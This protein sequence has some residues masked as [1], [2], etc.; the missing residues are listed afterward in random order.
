[1]TRPISG[2]TDFNSLQTGLRA[3][4]NTTG[5]GLT[6][7]NIDGW[8][9]TLLSS[10]TSISNIAVSYVTEP[11]VVE[12]FSATGANPTAF[13]VKPD[14]GSTFTLNAV[15]L[16]IA[17][18][19]T[20][21]TLTGYLAGS[22]VT[23]ATLTQAVQDSNATG[24]AV[25]FNVSSN[26]AFQGIDSFRIT[27]AS[28]AVSLYAVDN[29]NITYPGPVFTL[30]SGSAAFVEANNAVST[31]VP[32]DPGLTLA[33][34][35]STTLASATVAITVGFISGQ[36]FLSFINNGTEGNI[37]ASFNSSTGALTLTS[38]GGTATTAEWQ[39]ALR[40]V[41]YTDTAIVP[42]TSPRTVSFSANDGTNSS[43]AVSRGVTVTAT[44]QSP[45]VTPSSAT[46]VVST[47]PSTPVAIDSGITVTDLSAS[48]LASATVAITADFHPGEDVLAFN[49]GVGGTGNIVGSYN[50]ST[51]VLTL[52]SSGATATVAQFQTALRDVTFVDTAAA[53]TA[54]TRTI[55]FAVNDGVATSAVATDTVTIGTISTISTIS[56]GSVS[57]Y[58]F[59]DTT[60]GTQ[61]LT[62]NA[63]EASTITNP[64]SPNY[65]PNLVAQTTGFGAIS[66][67]ASDP[68][69]IAVYR[70]F[71]TATGAHF[72]TASASERDAIMNPASS[73]YN[74]SYVYEPNATFYEDATAQSGDVAV[75]RLFNSSNGTHFYTS[76]TTELAGLT[77]PG[78]ASYLPN[79]VAE[80]IAFYA[81]SG[82][83][84]T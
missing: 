34:P 81:P 28:S 77:T 7:T 11:G 40:A 69:E 52:T 60:T 48:T 61:F 46:P 67:A 21:V 1:M 17:G 72:F 58:R 27:S 13:V 29:I 35:T 3:S 51:G 10:A 76:D 59:F 70:F 22:P 15:D 78:S 32:V 74:A 43:T 62:A 82:A 30:S 5:S 84:P 19:S 36:D 68:N 24:T 75:Y 73:D 23:G 42:N 20:Q 53:P 56:P 47:T 8:D 41:A 6:A 2:T 33:D 50:G 38:A 44:H 9:F 14:D 39:A 45:I 71:D 80:G 55:S 63:S 83:T 26:S 12:G 31:P 66:P 65:Q 16:I 18:A 54:G 37:T 57:M 25:T 64:N 49:N 79:M 4:G